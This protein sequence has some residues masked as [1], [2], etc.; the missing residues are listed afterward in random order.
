MSLFRCFCDPN[1]KQRCAI[2][3][4]NKELVVCCVENDEHSVDGWNDGSMEWKEERGYWR[5]EE[6]YQLATPRGHEKKGKCVPEI[7]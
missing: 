6:T 2:M 5:V 1:G 3:N 7:N 4:R